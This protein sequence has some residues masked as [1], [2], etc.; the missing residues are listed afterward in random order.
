MRPVLAVDFDGVI[1][2]AKQRDLSRP[3]APLLLGAREAV[4]KLAETFDVVICTSRASHELKMVET[5]LT[6]EGF[7]VCGVTNEKVPAVA[8]VDDRAIRFVSWEQTL[9]DLGI[10]VSQPDP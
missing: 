9:A 4:N 2:E 8:Y 10:Q 5:F 1:V 6:D 7:R 3:F